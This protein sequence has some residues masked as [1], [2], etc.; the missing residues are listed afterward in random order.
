M[1]HKGNFEIVGFGKC[2]VGTYALRNLTKHFACSPQQL[3]SIPLTDGMELE[4]KSYM[5]KYCFENANKLP[6]GNYVEKKIEEVESFLDDYDWQTADWD[7]MYNAL[8]IAS[9]G[10]TVQEFAEKV[11]KE[12]NANPDNEE[13]KKSLTITNTGEPLTNLDGQQ[14]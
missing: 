6:N 3:V 10:M 14:D 9:F 5:L 2:L 4:W 13:E 8:W 1:A 11:K 12:G 7:N